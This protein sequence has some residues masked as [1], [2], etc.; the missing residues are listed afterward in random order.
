MDN[1]QLTQLSIIL[2]TFQEELN[3]QLNT[4]FEAN[5]NSEEEEQ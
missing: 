4:I 2:K 3:A 1:K 5:E